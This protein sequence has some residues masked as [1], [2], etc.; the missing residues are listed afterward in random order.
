MSYNIDNMIMKSCNLCIS[1]PN[2]LKWS[3]AN[4]KRLP[5]NHPLLGIDTHHFPSDISGMPTSNSKVFVQFRWSDEFSGHS[6]YNGTL[7]EFAADLEGDASFV[8]IW[9]GG[10]TVS[11][12]VLK[13]GKAFEA[14]VDYVLN[15]DKLK[16]IKQ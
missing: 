2:W 3:G 11:G 8:V 7:T 9:E 6:Y 10:D 13:D 14:E 5:T 12:L 15:M 16:E 4:E 1:Y